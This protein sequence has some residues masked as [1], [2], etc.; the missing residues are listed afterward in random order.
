[1]KLTDEVK[2]YWKIFRNECDLM[3]RKGGLR[4]AVATE[5]IPMV[6]AV[7]EALDTIEALQQENTEWQK[8]YEELDTGHS[9]LYKEFCEM[10]HEYEQLQAQVAQYRE[11]LKV[12]NNYIPD[13][14]QFC[15]CGNCK[16]C[17]ATISYAGYAYCISCARKIV[18]EALSDTPADYHNPADVA[19]IER[20][21]KEM[22][23]IC[24]ISANR[25]AALKKAR[26][27]LTHILH[28]YVCNF[29]CE[30]ACNQDKNTC[31][32]YTEAKIID[33]ALAAIDKIGGREDV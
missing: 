5:Q 21:N 28:T 2:G 4:E 27:A 20:L 13:T 15:V 25:L 16:I 31:N 17:G 12:A 22:D 8:N 9:R 24:L 1:M 18:D 7:L 19:D 10:K 14:G 32:C 11:A 33:E 3:L 30:T 29:K 26:E 23:G 6:D